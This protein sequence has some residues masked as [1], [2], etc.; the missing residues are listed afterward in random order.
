MRRDDLETDTLEFICA[1]CPCAKGISDGQIP[2]VRNHI[3]F[4][5][6]GNALRSVLGIEAANEIDVPLEKDIGEKEKRKAKP[7]RQIPT[8]NVASSKKDGGKKDPADDGFSMPISDG[9]KFVFAGGAPVYRIFCG[10][11]DI[12]ASFGKGVDGYDQEKIKVRARYLGKSVIG[13]RVVEYSEEFPKG[14][15]ISLE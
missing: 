13:I 2:Q 3:K 1:E 9:R 10:S 5:E 7:K 15:D 4:L 11:E 12:T 6:K 8:K 14:K